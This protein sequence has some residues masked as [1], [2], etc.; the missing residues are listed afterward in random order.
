MIIQTLFCFLTVL[1]PFNSFRYWKKRKKIRTKM[2]YINKNSML[3]IPH[4]NI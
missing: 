2:Q 1:T 3:T 4:P